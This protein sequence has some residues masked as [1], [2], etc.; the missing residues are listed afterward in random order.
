MWI[1][2]AQEC[3]EL[4][5]ELWLAFGTGENFR[6]IAAHELLACLGPEKVQVTSSVPCDHRL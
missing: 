4:I 6:Y 2:I 5:D 1:Y 3:H